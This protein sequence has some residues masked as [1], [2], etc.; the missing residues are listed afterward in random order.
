MVENINF[1]NEFFWVHVYGLALD[2]MTKFNAEAIRNFAFSRFEK[3]EFTLD[4]VVQ[5]SNYMRVKVAVDASK[6][7]FR[8][9]NNKR[10]GN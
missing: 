2:N 3:V 9:F 6:S 4:N 5:W 7:T 10:D 8:L 1:S